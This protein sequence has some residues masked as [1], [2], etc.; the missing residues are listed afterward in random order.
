MFPDISKPSQIF[1]ATKMH[2]NS[3]FT[4]G[5]IAVNVLELRD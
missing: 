4:A 2:Q 3:W 1:R 5:A